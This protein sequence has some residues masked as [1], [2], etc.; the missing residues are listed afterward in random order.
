MRVTHRM[1]A[2]T[3]NTNL[4]RSLRRLEVYSNQLSTGKVFHKPSENPVGVGRVMGYSAAVNRNEQYRLNMNQTRGWLEN[5]EASLRNGLDVLQRVRELSIY[6]ANE[7]LT[8]DDRRAIAPEI[9]EFLEHLIGIANTETNG[10]Y[11]FGGHQ[12]LSVPYRKEKVYHADILGGGIDPDSAVIAA[13]LQNGNYSLSQSSVTPAA[14]E[15]AAVRVTQ[16]YLQGNAESIIGEADWGDLV[17][18]VM[19]KPGLQAGSTITIGDDF[20]TGSPAENFVL[21]LTYDGTNNRWDYIDDGGNPQSIDTGIFSHYGITVDIDQ[22]TGSAADG[23][24]ITVA[25]GISSSVML[26]VTGVDFESGQV[27]YHYLS[28]QYA[29]DGTYQK[30]EGDFSLTFGDTAPQ[31]VTLGAVTVNVEGLGSMNPFLASGLKV[32]DRATL[33]IL[34]GM[35]AGSNYD[36]VTVNGEH[37]T[38][39]SAVSYLFDQDSL[40]GREFEFKYYSLDTFDRSPDKG[41]LYDGSVTVNY[42]VFSEAEQAL[43]FSYD[44]MGFPVY[45]GDFNDRVQEISPHQ[46]MIMNL[47]GDKAFGSN[48]EIFEAVYDV[49]WALIDNDRE[50]LGDT[51]L[52]KMDRAIDHFLGRLAEVGAR[53]NRVDAMNNTLS[54]ENLYLREVRSNIEDI[55]LAQVITDYLMQENAYKAALSTASMMLQPSLVD[56]LR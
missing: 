15:D 14:D 11:I 40:N 35:T 48:R 30:A 28:H 56:Y 12:T 19:I 53:S 1:I 25:S 36:Q 26:E 41:A 7:S 24:I 13:G 34:P 43:T 39:G 45:Y 10:L 3:V 49:Y 52:E 33:D 55:D 27:N 4:Q 5:T 29:L 37:R 51:A 46:E 42:G 50:A 18:G 9:L 20:V 38:G 8:A 16:S 23:D 32:G 54:N 44:K 47:S 2:D 17:N 6:G 21:T 31:S 22:L